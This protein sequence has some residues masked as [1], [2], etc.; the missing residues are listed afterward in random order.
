[1]SRYELT[2]LSARYEV[3]IGWDRPFGNFFLQVINRELDSAEED[4]IVLWIGADQRESELDVDRILEEAA[5]WAVVPEWVRPWLLADQEFEGTR[6]PP[7][8][9]VWLL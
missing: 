8:F 4:D 2:P 3:A 7:D 9:P 6:P 1:M 5:R